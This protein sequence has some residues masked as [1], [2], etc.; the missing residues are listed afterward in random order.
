VIFIF[1]ADFWDVGFLQSALTLSNEF[2]LIIGSKQARGAIDRRP[3]ARQL[4][5]QSF[6][7]M[8][9]LFFGY[10]GTDTHGLKAL[11]AG[12]VVPLVSKCRASNEL[13]DSELILRAQRA[14]LRLHEIP[15]EI[16]ERRSARVSLLR[17]VPGTAVDLLKM[18]WALRS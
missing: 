9:R 2:D 16:E 11:N 12:R 5:S 15:V 13:F 8:L 10:A 6:N 18:W 14:G 3:F 7:L 17:R 1:N 4:I